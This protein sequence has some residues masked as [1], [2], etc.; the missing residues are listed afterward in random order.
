MKFSMTDLSR[1][2]CNAMYD[3]LLTV[4]DYSAMAELGKV[5]LFFL[6]SVILNRPD[7]NRDWLY[8]RC[9]D[10]EVF[11][12]G[13]LDL[14]ARG[15]Y[16]STII[17]FAKTI[18][19]ILCNPEITIGIFSHTRPIAK[20]FLRQIMREFENNEFLKKLYPD[21]LWY[22]PRK[23]ALKWSEDGG[24]V[25][26]R[27]GNPKEAT[28]EAWGLVDGQP[29][30][31]HFKL[32]VYDDVVSRESV[33]SPEMISKT[34]SAWELSLNLGSEGGRRRYI[35]TRYH[36]ND[37][38]KTM[39]DRGSARLRLFPATDDGTAGGSPV[40]L[41]AQE[42]E[43]KRRDMGPYTF[44]AQMLQNPK[45][46]SAMGF[47]QTDIAY[48]FHVPERIFM[49]VGILVDPAHSKK[50]GSDYTTMSV[51]GLHHDNNYYLLDGLRCRYNL[52]ER[53]AALFSL[54]RKW[55]P[56]WIGYERYGLQSD[57]EHI[58][59]VQE[60]ESYRFAITELGGSVS[61][62]ERIRR[63][64]PVM[65][66]GRFYVPARLLYTD[67]EGRTCDYV[68]EFTDEL[69]GFPVGLHDDVID[70]IARV[71]DDNLCAVFPSVK[72][73]LPANLGG[74]SGGADRVKSNW[75]PL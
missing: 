74:K 47:Q 38:Y 41:T 55:A 9:R 34:T 43:E 56:N 70:G 14:W 69:L 57:I 17:T 31:R 32:V 54:H 58:R 75:K 19:D 52:M 2:E 67:H 15:H 72:Q 8:N 33:T 65:R 21:V 3:R 4:Q 37:T 53:T 16:K 7:V 5:D 11:P 48:Y 60:Q 23:D 50:K 73:R 42:L 6:L 44:G 24:I 51:L 10:V 20:A 59:Y 61:K 29:T 63:L 68:K 25:V 1:Q 13:R 71:L 18:Q 39:M 28:V 40:L 45:E 46:D 36:F 26:K 12:D 64:V 30:G 66:Q 22:E 62:E 35:G 27:K 49:N